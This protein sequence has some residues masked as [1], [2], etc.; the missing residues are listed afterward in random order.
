MS[1]KQ[2]L[3]VVEYMRVACPIAIQEQEDS[4]QI[5]VD[6]MDVITFKQLLEYMCVKAG[7]S[8]RSSR[9]AAWRI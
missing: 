2:N 5:Y 6:N 7:R 1:E 8:G 3:A 9:E 4:L